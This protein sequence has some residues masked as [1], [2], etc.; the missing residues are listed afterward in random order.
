MCVMVRPLMF[1]ICMQLDRLRRQMGQFPDLELKKHRSMVIDKV[2]FAIQGTY[3]H[4]LSTTCWHVCMLID[5]Y[6][7]SFVF[8]CAAY[9]VQV[10]SALPYC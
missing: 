3:L 5:M 6:V 9:I 7:R 2:T 10:W 1:L 4:V 8:S